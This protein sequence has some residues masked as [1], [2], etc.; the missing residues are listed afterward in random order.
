MIQFRLLLFC[1]LNLSLPANITHI[2][3]LINNSMKKQLKNLC[4]LTLVVMGLTACSEQSKVEKAAKAFV[5]ALNTEDMDAAYAV[6]PMA[7]GNSM[8][9]YFL[10]DSV[11][12]TWNETDSTYTLTFDQDAYALARWIKEEKRLEIFDSKNLLTYNSYRIEYLQRGGFATADLMDMTLKPVVDDNGY[13]NYIF[14]KFDAALTGNLT[15]TFKLG[16][17]DSF[18]RVT[19]DY[20][21]WN[22]GEVDVPKGAFKMEVEYLNAEGNVIT[23]EVE[24]DFDYSPEVRAH[25]RYDS[26]LDPSDSF[27]HEI[28]DIR[29]RFFFNLQPDDMILTYATFSGNE[30][31]EYKS[32]QQ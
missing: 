26:L 5:T 1:G 10:P 21:I 4:L 18:D 3:H 31:E 25:Q 12:V 22:N 29:G 14:Q 24:K 27:A 28:K 7:E 2:I 17:I 6:Y 20:T 32:Q 9:N 15:A 11:K 19:V 30:Y 8:Q 13:I 23:T 16:Y